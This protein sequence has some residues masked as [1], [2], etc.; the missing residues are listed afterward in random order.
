MFVTSKTTAT[1]GLCARAIATLTIIGALSAMSVPALAA[2]GATTTTAVTVKVDNMRTTS[3]PLYI[4]VQKRGDYM[5]Q[6]GHG[7]VLKSTTSGVMETT[8]NVDGAGDYAVSLWHDLDNDG[9]F[10]MG[11]DYRPKDGWVSSGTAPDD[12]APNF[13]DV[14]ISV[15]ASGRT[16]AL[17]MIYPKG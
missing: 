2:D 1:G 15:P 7:V 8:V 11:K 14:K 16:V 3:A 9:Q 10:T 6:A 4:S 13:D 17:S 5:K 12:R